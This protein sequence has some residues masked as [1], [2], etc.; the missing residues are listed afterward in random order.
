[1]ND[2][3]PTPPNLTAAQDAAEFVARIFADEPAADA[4]ATVVEETAVA[5]AAPE[6]PPVPADWSA[7]LQGQKLLIL[8]PV[9]A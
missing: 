8:G 5:Q 4:P 3:A 6:L 1:M 7:A 2:Q 9:T